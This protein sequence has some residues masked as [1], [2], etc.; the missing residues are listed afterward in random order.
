MSMIYVYIPCR[1]DTE[2]KNTLEDIF[3]NAQDPSN[4]YV[5]VFNQDLH[6]N[7]WHQRDFDYISKN[8]LIVSVDEDRFAGLARTRSLALSF[9]PSKAKYILFIDAHSRFDKHWD[10]NLIENYESYGKKVILSVYPNSYYLQNVRVEYKHRNVNDLN[11]NWRNKRRYT[12][13]PV[14]DT[15]SKY[16]RSAIAGGFLFTGIEW[17]EEVGF[18]YDQEFGWDELQTTYESVAKGYDI[19]NYSFPPIYHLY[20]HENRK[21]A[22]VHGNV[23]SFGN[24]ADLFA[25]LLTREGIDK[26]NGYYELDFI[27]WLNEYTGKNLTYTSGIGYKF[28]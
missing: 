25:K 1:L 27:Q 13:G 9:K 15:S 6:N 20:S 16:S 23:D 21:T 8:I 26:M 19:V 14:K 24:G 12:S 2:L 4:V 5:T 17:L 10:T 7:K 22:E 28:T 3:D 11:R 18:K